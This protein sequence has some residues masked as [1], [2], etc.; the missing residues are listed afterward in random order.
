MCDCDMRL[1]SRLQVLSSPPELEKLAVYVCAVEF[2]TFL[3]FYHLP[4][5]PLR[6]LSD[7]QISA[8]ALAGLI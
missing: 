1:C 8:L 3:A 7:A 2:C 6:R 5:K 4:D